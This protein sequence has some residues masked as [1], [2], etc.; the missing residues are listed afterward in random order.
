MVDRMSTHLKRSVVGLKMPTQS[1]LSGAKTTR[2]LLVVVAPA[3]VELPL[4]LDE[5]STHLNSMVAA[6]TELPRGS[7]MPTQSASYGAKTTRPSLVVVAP[8]NLKPLLMVDEMSTHLKRSVVGSKM[9]T[10]SASCGAKTTRPS[11]AVAAPLN[12]YSKLPS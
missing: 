10:Q 11:P 8:A 4:I 2:P 5:M 12:L 3:N 1:A 6:R 7:K 9:P